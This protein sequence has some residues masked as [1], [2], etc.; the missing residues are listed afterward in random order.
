MIRFFMK[1]FLIP[2][3]SILLFGSKVLWADPFLR[4]VQPFENYDIPPVESSFVFGSVLPATASL[5]ING[6]S[7]TPHTNGG[8]IK[9]IPFNEGRFKINAV[10]FDGVST[11]TV[12][13]EVNV[14]PMRS[15]FSL[16]EKKIRPLSPTTRVVVRPGDIVDVIFQGAPE[17]KATFRIGKKGPYFPMFEQPGDVRGI[18]QGAYSIQPNDKFDGADIYFGLR[19]SDGK[20]INSRARAKIIVQRRKLPRFVEIK[21]DA[22][23]LTGPGSSYGYHLFLDKGIRLE[24]TGELGNFL[25]VLLSRDTQ[26]WIKKSVAKELPAGTPMTRSIT[27]NMRI[28]YIEGNTLIELP[29]KNRHAYKIEQFLFPHR[30]RLTLYGVTPDTDRIRLKS[31]ETIVESVDWTQNEPGSVTFEILTKQEYAWGYHARYEGTTFMLE[32]RHKPENY[33]GR[34]LRGIRVALDAGHTKS[35]FGTIGPWG[36]TEAEVNLMISKVIKVAL[37]RRGAEVVMIQDGTKE[38]SLQNRVNLAWNE[39][40]DFF[41]SIHCDATG[42][43]NDPFEQQGFSV[44]Y[45]QPQSR[46]FAEILHDIYGEQM[47]ITDQGLW[48]SNLAVCRMPQMPSLLLEMAFLILPEYEELLLTEKFH[49][50]VANVLVSSLMVYLDESMK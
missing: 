32:I 11:T 19:R 41:I 33:S 24:V 27:R 16:T 18:Y 39:K 1:K 48:R 40:A 42:E 43:G 10:A 49:Q 22:V 46:P 14:A 2:V 15:S 28:D 45:Y 9:I 25:R 8:F 13:R 38:I 21:D 34:G 5:T 50:S 29:L 4:I 20:K 44:H 3:V 37:E 7:V 30:L 26:G 17:G 6:A 31:K 12:T 23:L 35:S 47:K 36:N